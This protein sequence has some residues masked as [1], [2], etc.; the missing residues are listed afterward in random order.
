MPL[1]TAAA[2]ARV[3]YNAF[4]L[5]I[6]VFKF[7]HERV[8]KVREIRLMEDDGYWTRGVSTPHPPPTKIYYIRLIMIIYVDGY[9]C[10][11]CRISERYVFEA[12]DSDASTRCIIDRKRVGGRKHIYFQ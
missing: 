1:D 4:S 8:S 2:A 12:F 3:T 5:L 6:I 7:R 10:G 9:T 11:V